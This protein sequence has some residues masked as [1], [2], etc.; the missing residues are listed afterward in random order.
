MKKYTIIVFALALVSFT[1]CKKSFIEQNNPNAVTVGDYF[2]TQSAVSLAVNGLYAGLRS[3]NNLG[4]NSSLFNDQH[5][6]D[7]GTNDISSNSGEPFQFA[8]YSLIASNSYINAHWL[9]LYSLISKC[10]VITSN[11]NNVT[12]TS[13]AVKQEYIAQAEF[14]R[15]LMYFHLVRKW[16]AVPLVTTQLNSATAVA[17]QTYRQPESAVYAQIVADLKDALTSDLPN[18]QT[19]ANAG[20]IGKAAMNGLLGEV[21]LTMASTLTDNKVENL[22]NANTYLTACYNMRPFTS[23]SAIPYADVFDVTKKATNPEAI[24]EIVNKQGDI[25]YSSSIAANNQAL[26]ETINSLK[27]ATSTGGNL[28]KDLINEYEAGDPRAAFNYKFA[29]NPTVFDYFITKYRDASAAAGVNGYGGN[30][31]PLMR[32]ADII[33]LLAE[34]NNDQGNTAVAI[35]YLDMVRARA[36]MPLYAV[37]STNPT[38][39][40][41][42]PTLKLAILH[43]RRSELAFEHQRWFDLIRNFTT[44]ELVSYFQAKN[45]LNFGNGKLANFGVKD[46]YFPIPLSEYQLD[47]VKMY[48]NPGY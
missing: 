27:V 44:P 4:E 29:S 45:P 14:I 21:Y 42:F 46:R 6:D 12:F 38:Y 35:Q 7:T 33:L 5:S 10:N 43:E 1:S 22:T 48:Q 19:G 39:A 3:G 32:Y 41:K 17:A 37:A 20:L 28:R 2:T 47:P 16:G 8:N 11:I 24:F 15:A 36:G 34:V 31:W 40:T 25:N 23:L 18:L 13:A 9:D 30:N 26:G